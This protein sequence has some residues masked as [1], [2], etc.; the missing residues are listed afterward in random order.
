VSSKPKSEWRVV[1]A[2]FGQKGH[3][4]H[5]WEKKDKAK[6]EQSK[7]DSDHHAEMLKARA[8]GQEDG[9]VHWYVGEAPY[10]VQTREVSKWGDV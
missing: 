10:V 2:N 7:V 6:A 3:A 9:R 8:A 4:Q 1:C 5:F